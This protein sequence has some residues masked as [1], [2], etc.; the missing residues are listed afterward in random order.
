L[1]VLQTL[2]SRVA[3]ATPKQEGL[4]TIPVALLE[5]EGGRIKAV[6]TDGH[7][8]ATASADKVTDI[9]DR[10]ILV[11]KD[12]FSLIRGLLD[13]AGKVSFKETANRFFFQTDVTTL[14]ATK[15]QATF[16][17]YQRVYPNSTA[18]T[19]TVL[20]EELK[21]SV[22]RANAFV[23]EDEDPGVTLRFGGG[24]TIDAAYDIR[25]YN[26]EDAIRVTS[27]V[28]LGGSA[29]F[30]INSQYLGDFLDL[31]AGELSI[32][33]AGDPTKPVLFANDNYEYLVGTIA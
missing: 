4:H 28:P 1:K 25:G 3:L 20:A 19:L 16:P 11:P 18:L 8:I 12:S 26:V 32:R 33:Y 27:S 30:K 31:T 15:Q 22:I 17:K 10:Q 13:S 6:A 21:D 24:D 23:N 14:V 5:I 7:R 9:Q 2:I 29:S